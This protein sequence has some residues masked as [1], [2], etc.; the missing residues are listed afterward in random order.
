L[1]SQFEMSLGQIDRKVIRSDLIVSYLVIVFCLLG[2]GLYKNYYHQDPTQLFINSDSEVNSVNVAVNSEEIAIDSDVV[3]S[4]IDEQIT[5]Q[6]EAVQPVYVKQNVPFTSQA[7]FGNWSDQRQQDG[8]EEASIVMGAHWAL[9]S[10]LTQQQALDEILELSTTAEELFGYYQDTDV[11]ETLTLLN[12]Y[13]GLTTAYAKHNPTLSDIKDLLSQG[14]IVLVP[15]NG[16]ALGNPNF[17]SPGPDRHMV[18]IVGYD[19]G[20]SEFI[21]NDPGTKQGTDYRYNEDV[22]FNAMRDYPS[23]DHEPITGQSKSLIVISQDR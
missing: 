18:V 12:S 22:L 3:L 19:P 21:T 9:G 2:Y 13:Y 8:C 5:N 6:P 1:I 15:T 7:P 11:E 4:N 20:T 16:Q 17:T 23:G 10:T 14:S